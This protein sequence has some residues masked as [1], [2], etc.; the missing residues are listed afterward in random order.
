MKD[1]FGFEESLFFELEEYCKIKGLGMFCAGGQTGGRKFF[2]FIIG[3]KNDT[4]EQIS[5]LVSH[6]L[7]NIALGSDKD[8]IKK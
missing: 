6:K 2:A 4:P 7:L 5:L 3:N 1:P 8:I